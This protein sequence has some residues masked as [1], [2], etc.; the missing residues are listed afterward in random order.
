MLSLRDFITMLVSS[1]MKSNS[2]SYLY[3]SNIVSNYR[4]NVILVYVVPKMDKA[5]DTILSSLYQNK[6]GR[7]LIYI[8]QPL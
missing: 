4:D 1:T 5:I 6:S 2:L 7:S 8:F 3:K